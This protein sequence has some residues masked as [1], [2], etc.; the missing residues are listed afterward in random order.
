MLHQY[1]SSIWHTAY[2]C[3]ALQQAGR[4]EQRVHTMQ[5]QEGCLSK[6]RF[7]PRCASGGTHT[8][9]LQRRPVLPSPQ[10]LPHLRLKGH[11]PVRPDLVTQPA[12]LVASYPC[13]CHGCW[14]L[15]G[16]CHPCQ[17]LLATMSNIQ[18]AGRLAP[19]LYVKESRG[20]FALSL[21][22]RL[23]SSKAS[24]SWLIVH[25]S[26]GCLVP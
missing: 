13:I 19:A 2:A 20:K 15:H 11:W 7:G 24:R 5:Q 3:I 18:V 9:N 8:S 16:G 17:A 4:T 10:Q 14:L 12:V 1:L 6:G 26:L 23:S 21:A 22:I 25:N